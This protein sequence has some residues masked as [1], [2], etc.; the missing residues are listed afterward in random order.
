MRFPKSEPVRSTAYRRLVACHPCVNCGIENYSQCAHGPALGRGMKACDLFTFPLCH[1]FGNGCHV[2]FDRYEL[3][4][5]DWRR[6]K[7][8]E[9]AAQ[10]QAAV[11][12]M[13]QCTNQIRALLDER[14][15]P[16]DSADSVNQR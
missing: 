5:A 12:G 16:A 14:G 4:D 9:W 13:K 2:K 7:A 1:E 15:F 6:E 8:L 3:G 10:T 11:L